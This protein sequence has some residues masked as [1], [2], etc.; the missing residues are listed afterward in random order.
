MASK[1]EYIGMSLYSYVTHY[2][3]KAGKDRWLGKRWNNGR[4]FDTEREAAIYVDKQLIEKG[5]EPIN[6]LIRK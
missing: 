3:N 1:L 5:R 4:V 6:I 2:K